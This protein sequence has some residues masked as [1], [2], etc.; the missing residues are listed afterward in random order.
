MKKVLL[1]T[2]LAVAG[3]GLFAQKV[4]KA[5]ELLKANKLKEAK[6]E[7]DN[8][9]ADA[10]NAKAAEGFYVKGKTYAAIANDS[11]I[12]ATVP[13]AR[14]TAFESLKKYVELDDKIVSLMIDNYKPIMDVYQ[15]Y[16][17]VGAAEFNQNKFPEAHVNFKNCLA[18]S[19]YMASKNWTNIKLDTTVILYTGIS[20]EK[21]GKPDEAAMY[22]G[23][24]ADA[25]VQGEGMVEIYKWLTDYHARK[26][27]DANMKKYLSLGKEVYPKDPFWNVYELDNLREGTDKNALF[28]KYEQVV[29]E[30]PTDFAVLYNYAVELY[31]A[32]YATEVSQ[33]PANSVEMI[34]KSETNMKKV[35]EMKN[36][37]TNAYLVLGQIAY[38]RGVD[39]NNDMKAIRPPAGGKL[40]PEELKKKD[41][42]RKAAM[43]K[44]D[45]AIPHFEKVDQLLGDKGKLKM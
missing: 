30:N 40:K 16:Y 11:V 23:R 31:T 5:K 7:I 42:L 13:D 45:E 8:F 27:D 22:Y 20:A 9:T 19:E 43:V 32:G 18:V 10:K 2:L 15:G 26:K 29:A 6:T 4:D 35:I 33:R 1:T 34:A 12:A 41:D 14:W 21:G 44:F 36:D 37:Y 25:K 39:I 17:K 24:L 38:N 3:L 28:T